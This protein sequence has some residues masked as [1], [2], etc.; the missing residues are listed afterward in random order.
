ML[1]ADLGIN[2]KD[3]LNIFKN[4]EYTNEIIFK[5]KYE[6]IS[7]FPNEFKDDVCIFLVGSYGRLEASKNSDLDCIFI[8]KKRIKEKD[9]VKITN[10]VCDSAK[11]IG[12]KKTPGDTGTFTE[13]IQLETLLRDIGG[14][15]D[16]NKNLTRRI[17]ILTES[18]FLYNENLCRDVLSEI[19][20]KYTKKAN[21][22]GKEP[23]ELINEIVR[24]YRTI[25]LDY[26]F[27]TEEQNK[28]WAVR[29]FKLRYSR[30]F[31]YVTTIAM[32][33]TAMKK[34]RDKEKYEYIR[35]HI[36]LPP[37]VKLGKVLIENHNISY[38]EPF[39]CYN[40]FLEY[41]SNDEIR[42]ELENL[43]YEKRYE[44]HVFREFKRNSDKFDETLRNLIKTLDG[45]DILTYK[46]IVL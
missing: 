24:Y 12:I 29:N 27:K 11:K 42:E 16:S 40:K 20:N 33:F 15:N 37:L 17:L 5:L 19:F 28:S 35:T 46:Y 6:L 3:A 44:S 45:W 22:S 9:K 36:N 32:I 2:L 39:I 31:L 4:Y 30:K 26:K 1:T 14:I 13:F 7:T 21:E 10:L 23:R 38:H 8:Y 34:V 43:P 41:L 18:Y 25:T